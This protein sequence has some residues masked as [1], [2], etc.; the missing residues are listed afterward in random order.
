MRWPTMA[1]LAACAG[2]AWLCFRLYSA[3]ISAGDIPVR[4]PWAPE[5]PSEAAFPANANGDVDPV[6]LARLV[7]SSIRRPPVPRPAEPAAA[8]PI[9][10]E[11]QPAAVDVA[12]P[13]GLVL[14]GILIDDDHRKAFVISPADQAG[15]WLESGGNVGG[16][17]ISRIEPGGVVLTHG[18]REVELPLY[19]SHAPT[20]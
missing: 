12:P 13:D 17:S 1:L 2:L 9:V 10:E 8:E 11:S 20:D 3:P 6:I 15:V 4:P 7:F 5:A 14:Q 16:W 19:P 18:N